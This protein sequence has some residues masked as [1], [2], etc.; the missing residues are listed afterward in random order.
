MCGLVDC[1]RLGDRLHTMMVA[2]VKLGLL[3]GIR[4][5]DAPI[6]RLHDV[7]TCIKGGGIDEH[8]GVHVRLDPIIRLYD[9]YVE[10]T[11]FI[12]AA[13]ACG[14]IALVGLVDYADARVFFSVAPHDVERTVGAA[15]V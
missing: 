11:R 3:W 13:V 2:A 14:T 5:E 1:E 15:I 12:K 8:V 4:H 9:G 10:A 7:Y 6:G